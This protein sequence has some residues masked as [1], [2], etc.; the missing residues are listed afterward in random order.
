MASVTANHLINSIT[1]ARAVAS[2]LRI[3][4][5]LPELSTTRQQNHI[6][7]LCAEIM[8]EG[9]TVD[10]KRSWSDPEEGTW[11]ERPATRFDIQDYSKRVGKSFGVC[12]RALRIASSVEKT[13][14]HTPS[15]LAEF[16]EFVGGN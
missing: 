5:G 7:A 11:H 12:L 6:D 15:V 8:V 1:D 16:R 4:R 10:S 13:T 14:R 3:S 9:Y 2:Q